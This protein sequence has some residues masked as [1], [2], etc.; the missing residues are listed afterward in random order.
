MRVLFIRPNMSNTRAFDAMEPLVFAI[1]AGQTPP[2]V[3]VAFFDERLEAIPWQKPADLVALTVETFTARR[4]YQIAAR[5]RE[6]GTPVV[7]GGYHP[8]LLPTEAGQYADAVVVGDGEGIW[9]QIIWDA[10]SRRLQPIYQQPGQPALPGLKLDRSIFRGKRYA[11]LTLVQYGRGCRFACDFCSIHAFYGSHL[12][13]RPVREVVA[14]IEAREHNLVFLVD[15]NI[16]ADTNKARDL[17]QALIPLNIQWACQVSIDVAQQTELLDLMARSGCFLV[18]IGFESLDERNLIQMKKQWNLKHGDYATAVAKFYD[19][20][21]MI[22]ATFVF[23]YD[24]DTVDS[25]DIT[26]D[27][28]LR[29]KF[30]LANFNPLMPMPGTRLYHRLLAE[31]RLIYDHWWLDPGF[32]YGQSMFHPRGMTAG[33]LANGCFRARREFNRYSSIFSRAL[34]PKTNCRSPRRLA[35]Y[36]TAN[37]ISRKEIFRKQGSRLGS[38]PS[39]EPGLSS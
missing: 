30:A 39:P 18:L 26:L 35:A 3:E 8:T 32:R 28:A 4:A 11:P 38:G 24:Y 33:E 36:L 12:Y 16:F 31:G 17:F 15:D 27:F 21:M 14:E 37:L 13:H 22:Y 23:G 6:R 20:G 9:P 19:R 2:E 10:Q 34:E 25:F 29:S 1:L 5:F 7:L